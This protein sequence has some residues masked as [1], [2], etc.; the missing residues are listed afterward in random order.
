MIFA[1]AQVLMSCSYNWLKLIWLLALE[2]ICRQITRMSGR[3]NYGLILSILF[4]YVT[5]N[6]MCIK[7][8]DDEIGKKLPVSQFTVLFEIGLYMCL[9]ECETYAMCLSINFNRKMLMCE[10]NSQKKN[11][12]LLLVDDSDFIYKDLP[13]IVSILFL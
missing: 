12:S 5:T 6:N 2:L 7:P 11:E 1:F 8:S 4:H 13:G 10:L 9:K 3:Y